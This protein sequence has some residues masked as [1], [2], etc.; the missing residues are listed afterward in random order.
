MRTRSQ[1]KWSRIARI[2]EGAPLRPLNLIALRG[3]N[4][5]RRNKK[6]Q[7]PFR[8]EFLRTLHDVRFDAPTGN[9]FNSA[10]VRSMVNH[11]LRS[12]FPK[13]CTLSA[14]LRKM[15]CLDNDNAYELL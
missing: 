7:K 4:V 3:P 2:S 5:I 10:L 14:A 13:D 11:R 15:A 8:V 1:D 12:A 9:L 6:P